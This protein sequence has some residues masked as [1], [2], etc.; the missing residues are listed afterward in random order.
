MTEAAQRQDAFSSFMNLASLQVMLHELASGIDIRDWEIMG[1]FQP[2]DLWANAEV[3]DQALEAYAGE[4]ARLDMPVRRY[5]CL[6]D[7][8]SSY[9]PAA[10][11]S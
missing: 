7:F 11:E 4:Y 6:E 8:L 1:R 3:F 5:A 9:L 2:K 10:E